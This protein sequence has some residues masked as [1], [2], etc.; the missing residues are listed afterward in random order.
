MAPACSAG[1][2]QV[3]AG[4]SPP[5]ALA[6]GTCGPGCSRAGNVLIWQQASL[7]AGATTAD[8]VT[9]R[10]GRAGTTVIL[11]VAVSRTRDP[12]PRNNL[13]SALITIT[14]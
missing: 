12:Q 10:A 8:T 4:L 1:A 14:R 9:V 5:A 6:P 11:G 7:A 13:A 2:S 3:T